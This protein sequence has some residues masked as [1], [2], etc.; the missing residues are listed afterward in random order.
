MSIVFVNIQ[1]WKIW[2][3]L[4]PWKGAFMSILLFHRF[5]VRRYSNNTLQFIWAEHT[6]FDLAQRMSFKDAQ[7]KIN[8]MKKLSC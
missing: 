3:C 1:L 7:Q 2:L 5:P 8:G 4:T 6:N